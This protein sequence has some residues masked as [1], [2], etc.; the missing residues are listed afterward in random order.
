MTKHSQSYKSGF[1]KPMINTEN[2]ARSPQTSSI[3]IGLYSA[4]QPDDIAK[5]A[6]LAKLAFF[7]EITQKCS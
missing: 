4:S 5:I 1:E 6:M 3:L 7:E 2:L